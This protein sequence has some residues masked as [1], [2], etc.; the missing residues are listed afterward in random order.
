M[1]NKPIRVLHMIASLSL[2]GSQSMVMNLY[3][4]MDRKKIQ[5]DFIIDKSDKIELKDDIGSWVKRV[6]KLSI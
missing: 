1:Q 2:G 5:F 6:V 3:R 4:A